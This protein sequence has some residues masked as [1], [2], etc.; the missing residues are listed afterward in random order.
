MSK[1]NPCC[2]RVADPSIPLDGA[3]H[4]ASK[5]LLRV[6]LDPGRF[7]CKAKGCQFA[8]TTYITLINHQEKVHPR[9]VFCWPC[10]KKFRNNVLL[11]E[12]VQQLH[13]LVSP[14][15]PPKQ[16]RPDPRVRC[17]KPKCGLQMLPGATNHTCRK[18]LPCDQCDK[19]FPTP[20]ALKNHK[21]R[22]TGVYT[23]VCVKCNLGFPVYS[24]Y[25]DHLESHNPHDAYKCTECNYTSKTR[26]SLRTHMKRHH[27]PE[28]AV[29]PVQIKVEEVH[30]E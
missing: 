1:E 11:Q 25:R 23:L 28:A 20:T 19:S 18:L 6:K 29:L 8:A 13:P 12:H 26:V 15:P 4:K 9:R 16:K 22:H 5:P 10:R 17:T 21:M 24:N 3:G 7:V 2:C 27:R 30:F 14:N